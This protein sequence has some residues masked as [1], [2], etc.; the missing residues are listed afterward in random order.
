MAIEVVE[1][2]ES[3]ETTEGDNPQVILIYQVFGTDSDLAAKAAL[4]LA[5]P[6]AYDGLVK[7]K[8]WIDRQGVD[9]WLGKVWYTLRAISETGEYA[10][11]TT[12]GT[13]HITQSKATIGNY[14]ASGTAPNFHGA[15][16]VTDEG[17]VEG[18][19]IT[20]PVFKWQER[21][22]I[23]A[24]LISDAYIMLIHNMTGTMNNV[25][26]RLFAPGEGLFLG[27]RGALR[28]REGWDITYHFAGSKNAV[29]IPV[30]DII[31]P[32]KYG[33]DYLW[34]RYCADEDTSAKVLIKRPLSAH[35]DRVYDQSNFY[36][37]GIG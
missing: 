5:S 23:K 27:A 22:Q 33:W 4:D 37:L 14:A 3:R 28:G 8:L 13:Q 21:H 2:F 18:T 31:V 9:F 35:V 11:D 1:K 29:A 15:L 16:G 20:V 32:S 26:W 34:A 6:A 7:S 36:A 24:A 30:G 10:F 25:A 12:G 19:D 17:K